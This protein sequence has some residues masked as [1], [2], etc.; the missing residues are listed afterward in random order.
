MSLISIN[1]KFV[2][3][4]VLKDGQEYICTLPGREGQAVGARAAHG[5][6]ISCPFEV[7]RPASED[8]I[9]WAEK[10]LDLSIAA[11]EREDELRCS[12]EE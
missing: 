9:E 2:W 10:Q 8:E 1:E 12:L 11:R 3:W 7:V 4:V 6:F 5:P